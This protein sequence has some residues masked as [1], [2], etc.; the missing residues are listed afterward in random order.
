MSSVSQ[1]KEMFPQHSITTIE[2][3]LVEMNGDFNNALS[4]LLDL[5]PES[6][7]PKPQPKPSNQPP[8]SKPQY[9]Q[10]QY[11]QPQYQQPPNHQPIQSIHHIFSNDFLRWPVG[12]EVI[13]TF[14]DGRNSEQRMSANPWDNKLPQNQGYYPSPNNTSA[15]LPTYVGFNIPS[16]DPNDDP[17]PD[18]NIDSSLLQKPQQE[19]SGWW[20][21]FKNKFSNNAPNYNQL[22]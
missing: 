9:Q 14:V 11:Q 16:V 1:L 21:S 2:R 22:N 6:S 18:I 5:P 4:I 7:A 19:K 15:P 20:Q 8:P 10:P 3:I 17:I 13:K 12:A